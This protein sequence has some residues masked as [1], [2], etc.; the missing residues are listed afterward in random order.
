MDKCWRWLVL[1]MG[2]MEDVPL[3]RAF[4]P[5]GWV[6]NGAAEPTACGILGATLQSPQS[7]AFGCVPRYR[8]ALYLRLM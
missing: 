3:A 7:I 4:K 8:N 5:M 2:R 1:V 6:M